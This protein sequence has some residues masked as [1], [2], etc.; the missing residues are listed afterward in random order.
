MSLPT[1]LFVGDVSWDLTLQIDHVPAP[2]EKVHSDRAT[3]APGGVIGNAAVAAA[4]AGASVKTVIGCGDDPVGRDIVAS[5]SR[6]GIEVEAK[7][8]EGL[9]CRCVILVEPH[10]EK[11]LVL[12]PGVSMYPS[13]DQLKGVSLENIGWVHTAIYDRVAAAILIERCR[14]NRIPWSIDL[15]P[16]TFGECIDGLAP[17]L[18]GAAVIFCN[19]RAAERLGPDPVGR[20]Q[21]LGATAILLTQ[22]ASGATWAAGRIR[23]SVPTP[24]LPIVDTTGAGDCLA[25][26]FISETLRGAEASTALSAAVAAAT[27]SCGTTGAQASFPDRAKVDAV[28]SVT[29]WRELIVSPKRG[30]SR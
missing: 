20:L 15:E 11:R 12:H 10:G 18:A 27:L 8:R 1:A 19:I 5:M 16:A 22:G 2:D 29:N 17:L 26:W 28:L 25:G 21:G 13:V 24:L 30:R 23:H 9:T 7:T 4:L 3:E 6:R 14:G